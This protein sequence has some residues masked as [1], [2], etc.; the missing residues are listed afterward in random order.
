VS[1]GGRVG[2][3]FFG[4]TS[5]ND[6]Q[7]DD[8]GGG[9]APA[10]YNPNVYEVGPTGLASNARYVWPTIF[11]EASPPH[12]I[13]NA[14]DDAAASAGS[15]LVVVYPGIPQG[16]RI[17]PLGAYYE[18]I[19]MQSPVKLQGVGPGGINANGTRAPGS[20]IDGLAFGGDAAVVTAWQAKL[21]SLTW[22]GNQTVGEGQ[23]IT[24][25]AQS[26]TQYGA[27]YKAAI[28]GFDIRGGDQQGQAN[29]L[30]QGGAIY[31][32]AYARN[33][34][35]TN[36]A[37]EHN[38]A[39]YG[40]V[41]IGTP[42]LPAP[43]TS[44]HNENLVIKNNR[45]FAN[46]GTN[47]AGAI[48][49]FA[50]ADNYEVAANDLCGN[51][52][53]EYGGA[54]SHHGLSPN[55]KIHDNRIYYN[56]SYDEGGGI[57]IAGT[58]PANATTLSPGAGAVDIYN[59]LIQ[60]NM[61]NDDGGG[62]RFLMAGNFPFNV[63]NNMIVNNVST[64]EGGGVAIDDAPNVR[65]FNNTVMR[66]ITTATAVTSDGQPAAAGLSTAANSD[67]LQATLPS[68]SPLF[69][70]PLLFNNI[71]WE[72]RAGTRGL[73]TVTGL[74][75]ADANRWDVGVIGNVGLL[76]P[77][78]SIVQQNA[79]VHPY[80]T[81]PTNSTADPLVI[82]Q[83]A[84]VLTFAPWRTNVNLIGAIM[85][86]ADNTGALQGNYHIQSGSPA[87]SLGAASK[88]VPTYQRPPNP[89]NAPA[90]DFDNQTRT[91]PIAAGADEG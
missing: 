85:V 72:N 51:F 33:L 57:T 88:V 87:V 35:I 91:T 44:Q 12:P 54:I 11:N 71:F 3:R 43:D 8:F 75:D 79:G 69:S 14:L 52:S 80:T 83:Y 32:N 31:A 40:S 39:S 20:I 23:V 6:A 60:G 84:T 56:Q 5:T 9:N 62:I 41:R 38:N 27:T 29:L 7:F 81:S 61:A 86:T 68:G 46:S 42:N 4:P 64:H 48:G 53:A 74:T 21:A 78:N 28:D 73:N 19:I 47:L 76:A 82:T 63:Y 36:N 10:S 70:N 49:L 13:Q 18:N 65:F 37:I 59:N 34:Q 45:I 77:T 89:L 1:G 50:G 55:G 22:V 15:D 66:N 17:N 90:F 26:Q 25:L 30:T 58:L 16:D 2:V 67:L 24:V